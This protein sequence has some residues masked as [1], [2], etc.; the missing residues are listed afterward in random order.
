MQHIFIVNPKAGR[1]DGEKITKLIVE[2]ATKYAID[3]QIIKTA[4]PHHA[5]E[6]AQK[7]DDIDTIIYALGGDGSAFDIV[8]GITKA[9]MAIL[10]FG[11]GN[12][13][14]RIIA[15]CKLPAST[16][17]D[18]TLKG[19]TIA[20]DYG[21]CNDHYFLNTTTI[22]I[23]AKVNDIV[24]KLLK[25]TIIPKPLLYVIGALMAIIK[26]TYFKANIQLDKRKITQDCLLI[27]MMNGKYY[28][29]GVAPIKDI[30]L[31]DGFFDICIVDKLPI[32][33]M[34]IYLPC[35]FLGKTAN[36]PYIHTYKAKNIKIT[37]DRPMIAQSDGESFT[38]VTFNLCNLHKALHYLL[39]NQH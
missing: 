22:G 34:L 29:N 18:N 16:L 12:D 36:I 33:K 39:P 9:T 5:T 7:Y 30:D 10:P 3:Y 28:G 6:I 20:I 24:C 31:T 27:A 32:Y 15:D 38:S 25:K 14:Y 13:F 37:L 4:Y 8:N 11:T 26:P 17:L 21:K 23:D 1:Y 19:E 35:Y 2:T